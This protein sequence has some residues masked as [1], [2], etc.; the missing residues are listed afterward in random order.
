MTSHLKDV[1]EG[2]LAGVTL[3]AA[4]LGLLSTV[5][6]IIATTLTI[7]WSAIKISETEWWK[8]RRWLRWK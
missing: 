1:V 7:L 3:A 5:L 8:N 6:T 2:G 4:W